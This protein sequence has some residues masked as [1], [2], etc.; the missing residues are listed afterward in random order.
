MGGLFRGA[1]GAIA[2]L[3]WG[4]GGGSWRVSGVP[5][6][7][8]SLPVK[9]E[10]RIAVFSESDVEPGVVPVVCQVW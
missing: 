2:G 5:A 9:V 4:L 10:A 6:T 7:I 1:V 8:F 3:S